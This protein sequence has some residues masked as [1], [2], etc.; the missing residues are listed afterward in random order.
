[1][2]IKRYTL[3]R[4]TLL[5]FSDLIPANRAADGTAWED[6]DGGGGGGG[7]CGGGGGGGG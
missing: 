1:M 7:V 6:W 4:N 3:D 5:G 2:V